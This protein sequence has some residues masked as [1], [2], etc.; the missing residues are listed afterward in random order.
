MNEA[1]EQSVSVESGGAEALKSAKIK[2]TTLA[3][4]GP[5]LPFG[6]ADSSGKLVKGIAHRPWKLKQ[7]KELGKLLDQ[8]RE[9]NL[10]QYT[11]M[12]LATMYTQLGPHNLE[13]MKEGERRLLVGQLGMGDAFYAYCWLRSESLGNKLQMDLTC[14]SCTH[15]FPFTADLSTLE[16]GTVDEP[17]DA[18]W[19]YALVDQIE[20]RGQTV[21]KLTLSSVK[22]Q[23]LEG[24]SPGGRFNTGAAKAIMIRSCIKEFDALGQIA[25]ADHEIDELSKRDVEGILRGI[26]DNHVGPDMSID[27]S[28]PRCESEFRTSIDWEYNNFFGRSSR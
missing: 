11:S 1:M 16:V 12:V 26:D 15:K 28:C 24:A 10:V 6:I 27:L 20:L 25:I 14:P 17:K 21:T 23:D 18:R 3:E 4:L 13:S 7:E 9:A 19:E 2:K 22:W 5:N 8:H